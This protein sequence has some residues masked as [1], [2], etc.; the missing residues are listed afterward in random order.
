MTV[1]H[2]N[3]KRQVFFSFV[4]KKNRE[5][6]RIVPDRIPIPTASAQLILTFNAAKILLI[7]TLRHSNSMN[8]LSIDNG[9]LDLQ[10]S[11]NSLIVFLPRI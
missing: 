3:E 9:I 4:A 11:F 7:M 6:E 5:R 8:L 2:V 10:K 1:Y